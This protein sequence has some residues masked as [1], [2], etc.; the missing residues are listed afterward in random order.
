MTCRRPNSF[1]HAQKMQLSEN[2]YVF[3]LSFFFNIPSSRGDLS[4]IKEV[5][6]IRAWELDRFMLLKCLLSHA[7]RWQSESLLIITWNQFQA[8]FVHA[9][10]QPSVRKTIGKWEFKHQPLIKSVGGLFLALLCAGWVSQG[11]Y[12]CLLQRGVVGHAL[13]HPERWV[14]PN[15]TSCTSFQ[16]HCPDSVFRILPWQGVY[17]QVKCGVPHKSLWKWCI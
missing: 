15:G 10:F 17:G 3:S 8:L 4:S 5:M 11:K 16:E 2:T 13:H 9:W 7:E 6:I 14:G 12:L 1:G